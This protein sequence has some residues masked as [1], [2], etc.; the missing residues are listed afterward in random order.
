MRTPGW[1]AS[2][3]VGRAEPLVPAW[4]GWSVLDVC[5]MSTNPTPCPSFALLRLCLRWHRDHL[6]CS[7][8]SSVA[9]DLGEYIGEPRGESSEAGECAWG[10]YKSWDWRTPMEAQGALAVFM[11]TFI[12]SAVFLR[13]CQAMASPIFAIVTRS[14]PICQS[15][16]NPCPIPCPA[17]AKSP[18]ASPAL[19]CG[20]SP[21]KVHEGRLSQHLFLQDGVA[22]SWS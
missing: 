7:V 12:P 19:P 15:N 8:H 10:H 4:A 1:G 13:H 14:P 18:A 16:L 5:H 6:Y 11:A 21:V 2:R 20:P 22:S 9:S 17:E 3:P